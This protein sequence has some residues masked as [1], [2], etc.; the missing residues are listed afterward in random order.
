MDGN[1]EKTEKLGSKEAM[2]K[3]KDWL[4]YNIAWK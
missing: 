1:N 2:G 3:K 4:D